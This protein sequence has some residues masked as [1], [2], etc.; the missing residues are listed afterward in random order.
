MKLQFYAIFYSVLFAHSTYADP[1]NLIDYSAIDVGSTIDF[2]SISGGSAPGTNYNN[3]LTFGEVL[4]GGGGINIGERF[5]GQS[6]SYSGDSDILSAS[7]SSELQV[8]S[9]SPNQNL[10]V[11]NYSGSNVLTG[12]GRQGFPSGNAIGE[13]SVAI[14]FDTDQSQFGFQSVGGNSG[15]ATFHFFRRDGSLIDTITPT[16]LTS[17]SFG[18]KRDE[19][20]RDI[21]GISIHNTDPGG[22]G[23]DNFVFDK[24]ETALL[25]REKGED[26]SFWGRF[27]NDIPGFD[28]VGLQLSDEIIW[29]SHPGYDTG[30]YTDPT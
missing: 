14:L 15:S 29:E 27:G 21:A 10:N 19:G 5:Q 3:I 23:Y 30:T 2:N 16:E 4:I 26:D 25:F 13:G 9:G 17:N 22:I 8:I 24:Q 12:L 7:A 1:I 28:H 18:V 20:V 6:L 11:F